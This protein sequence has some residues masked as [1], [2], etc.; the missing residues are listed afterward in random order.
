[1]IARLVISLIVVIIGFLLYASTR[2]NT[3]RVERSINIRATP[4]KIFSFLN[5][6]R[7]GK[8]WSPWMDIDPN[9]AIT[10]SGPEE[11]VG[12]THEWSGNKKIGSGRMVIVESV[13]NEKVVVTLD[14]FTPFKAH[15][16]AEFVLTPNGDSTTNL[17]WAT[18]GPQPFMA[19]V[20]SLIINCEKMIGPHFERGLGKLKALAEA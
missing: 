8:E 9:M 5:N 11:G 10:F 4:E 7:R 1:M 13:P 20:M 6:L 17:M 12:A 3:F 19:K 14:F 15:N 16:M 2:A 18:Y